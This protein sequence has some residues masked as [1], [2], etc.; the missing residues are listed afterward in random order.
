M[1][2]SNSTRFIQCAIS[3]PASALNA[4]LSLATIVADKKN[5]TP[6]HIIARGSMVTFS[7]T[8][9]RSAM[10]ITAA[11][12]ATVLEAGDMAVS[13]TRLYALLS[14][15]AP[16]TKITIGTAATSATISGGSS[17]YRLPL[18]SEPPASLV[19]DPEI[20]RIELPAADLVKLLGVLPAADAGKTRPYLSGICLHDNAG[21]LVSVATDTTKLLKFSVQA[22]AFSADRSLIIPASTATILLKILR[23]AKP[24]TVTLRRSQAVLAVSAPGFA[25]VSGMIAGAFPDYARVI[26]K[27]S[28]N[29]AEVQRAEIAS[30]LARHAAVAVGDSPLIMLAWDGSGPLRLHLAR[31]PQAGQD[32]VASQASGSAKMAFSLP[33][34]VGLID[35]FDDA[36]I[37]IEAAE[38]GILIRQGDKSAVLMSCRWSETEAAA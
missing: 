13:A 30:A 10:A 5:D 9:T 11:T 26:P 37:I 20:G 38:R 3:A 21:R 8:N 33:E 6:V 28:G 18:L 35:E 2:N 31:Q 23:L 4:A 7:V 32:D 17:H 22:D 12:G 1:T 16:G 36:A 29:V 15:F 27:T 24:D 19:I 25:L 14:S 34:L